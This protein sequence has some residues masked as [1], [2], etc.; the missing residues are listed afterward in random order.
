MTE[1]RLSNRVLAERQTSDVPARWSMV[2]Y[3]SVAE[4]SAQSEASRAE[5]AGGSWGRVDH[6]N[7][8]YTIVLRSIV[9]GELSDPVERDY[10]YLDEWE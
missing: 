9:R 6:E 5:T 7:G 8:D 10:S 4:M 2:T 1:Q 3:V